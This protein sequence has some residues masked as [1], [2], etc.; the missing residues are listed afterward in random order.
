MKKS[1]LVRD[2]Q[3]I[4]IYFIWNKSYIK[5]KF[6]QYTQVIMNMKN[7]NLHKILYKQKKLKLNSKN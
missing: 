6:P 3:K 4:Y 1:F 7:C 5:S 2:K